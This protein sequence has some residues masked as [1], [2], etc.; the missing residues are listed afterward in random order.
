MNEFDQINN[1]ILKSLNSFTKRIDE[2]SDDR[3]TT[4]RACSFFNPIP[5]ESLTEIVEKSR[6]VTFAAGDEITTEHDVI[7]PFFV[8]VFGTA[9]AYVH[10]Q[11]VGRILSGECV[12]ES[13]F[14]TKQAPSRLATVIA[15]GELIAVE[16]SQLDIQSISAETQTFLD[17]ALL[18][19][20]FRKLQSANDHLHLNLI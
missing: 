3:F 2:V 16:I 11:E 10:E 8:I 5:S 12:G 17:K 4:L 20:L 19:A 15:D 1:D 18:L 7:R 13:A 9:T 6:I 14:F